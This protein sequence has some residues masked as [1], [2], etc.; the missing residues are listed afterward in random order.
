M[1]VVDV[2]HMIAMRDGVMPAAV[3]VRVVVTP[4]GRM[5]GRLALVVVVGVEPVQMTVVRVVDMVA[6]RDLGMAAG[7]AMDVVVHRV[8]VVERGHGA[9]LL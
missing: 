5:A 4:V 9:H 8:F 6:V 2:V 3:T 1:P 7:R